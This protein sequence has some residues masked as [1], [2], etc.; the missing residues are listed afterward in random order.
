MNRCEQCKYY[1]VLHTPRIVKDDIRVY[2]FCFKDL[3]ENYGSAYPVYVPDGGVCKSFSKKKE[4]KEDYK[5]EM[6]QEFRCECCK[7]DLIDKISKC[8]EKGGET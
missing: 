3:H 8:I 4:E 2:G 1:G 7:K 6:T 5:Y